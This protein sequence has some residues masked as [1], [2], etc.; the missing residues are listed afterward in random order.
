MRSYAR[1]SPQAA[2]RLVALVLLADG[3]ACRS[4]FTELDRLDATAELGLRDGEFLCIVQTL[5][6]DLMQSGHPCLEIDEPTLLLL[7]A[8]I[9]DAA[10][11]RKVLAL[12]HAAATADSHLANGEAVILAAANRRWSLAATTAA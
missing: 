4:E 10:L 5:C 8:E 9:D 1:N 6:E 7:M 2:A 3:H 12:A 11:Q